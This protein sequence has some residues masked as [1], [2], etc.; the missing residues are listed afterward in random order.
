PDRR[1]TAA[2]RRR[3]LPRLE[4]SPSRI[5]ASA[6]SRPLSQ[7]DCP[8]RLL[9]QAGEKTPHGQYRD[10]FAPIENSAREHQTVAE[11]LADRVSGA[12]Q[13]R[14]IVAFDFNRQPLALEVG[15]LRNDEIDLA[16]A[17]RAPVSNRAGDGVRLD[18]RL[19]GGTEQA[20]GNGI[21]DEPIPGSR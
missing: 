15:H 13:T 19:R 9:A 8:V 18:E 20:S 7:C 10:I 21:L 2:N 16:I 6:D 12:I 11:S 4:R 1:I 5:G 14:R 3:A 17:T